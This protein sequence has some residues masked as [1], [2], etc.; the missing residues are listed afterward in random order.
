MWGYW[1]RELCL[2][3]LELRMVRGGLWSQASAGL[4]WSLSR[5]NRAACLPGRG[6]DP[7]SGLSEGKAQT[8]PR[9]VRIS[10]SQSW[11]AGEAIS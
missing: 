4:P 1:W 6:R 5:N 3:G 8:D 2:S 10:N 11:L 9:S 7:N